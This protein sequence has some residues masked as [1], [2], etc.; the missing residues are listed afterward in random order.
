MDLSNPF[1][2][3]PE[4]DTSLVK[5]YDDIRITVRKEA[6]I[7]STVFPQPASVM[8]VFLQRVFAQ[9]V[10]EGGLFSKEESQCQFPNTTDSKSRRIAIITRRRA[11]TACVPADISINTCWNTT[12]RG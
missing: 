2:P 1:V 7:I 9:S 3:P 5:L 4:V 11:L 8:Q 12:A 10:S 6:R